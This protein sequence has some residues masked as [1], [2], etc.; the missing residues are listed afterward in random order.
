MSFRTLALAMAVAGSVWFQF[1]QDS[2]AAAFAQRSFDVVDNRPARSILIIGNSR[3]Y[4]NDMPAM[5]REIADSAGDPAKF[6]VETSAFGGAS[7]ESL[8]FDHRTKRLLGAGWDD[9]VMQAESRAQWREELNDSFLTYG[10]KLAEASRLTNGRPRLVVNWAYDPPLYQGDSGGVVRANHLELIK[11][12]HSR[13][14]S[15]ADMTTVKLA[16]LWETVRGR[17]PSI[18]LT[19]DGNHPTIAGSYLFALAL[20]ANLSNGSVG[21]VTYAPD[22]I[23]PKAAEALR[24]AV[25][26][27]PS[28]IG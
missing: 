11:S 8:W 25:D 19:T 3:T 4:F 2:S 10:S 17:H 12:M 26:A 22:E 9:V 16:G 6:Q 27:Y 7:F 21:E 23:D 15:E 28:L 14:G 13:L 20:Y 1:A 18:K 24:S 5:L